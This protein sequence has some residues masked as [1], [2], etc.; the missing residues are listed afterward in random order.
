LL[1]VA[2]LLIWHCSSTFLLRKFTIYS[3]VIATSLLDFGEIHLS[4]L[5]GE[6]P[7][8]SKGTMYAH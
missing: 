3:P 1:R 7:I 4:R 2:A 8:L 6:A 5:L